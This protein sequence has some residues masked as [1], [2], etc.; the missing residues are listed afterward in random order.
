MNAIID[1]KFLDLPMNEFAA[2]KFLHLLGLALW[3]GSALSCWLFLLKARS[4]PDPGIQ[5]WARR[6]VLALATVKHIGFF[7]LLA[8]GVGML[9]A[10][11]WQAAEE[12]KWLSIKI[13]AA[14][15]L[16]LPMEFTG[17]R[18]VHIYL[19]AALKNASHEE[20]RQELEKLDR[21]FF[22]VFPILAVVVPALM[23]LAL[24]KWP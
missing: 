14:A 4:A 18:L 17:I 24:M 13:G 21:H 15:L 2:S 6:Q 8:G 10:L 11:G 7:L 19:P 20:G 16:L 12:F 5:A 1:S 22:I 3:F 9:H 23:L